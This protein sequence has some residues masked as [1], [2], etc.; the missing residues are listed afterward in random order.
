MSAISSLISGALADA[1][2]YTVFAMSVSEVRDI[3]AVKAEFVKCIGG[4]VFPLVVHGS[5]Q[6]H[7]AL[8]VCV[9]K[10]LMF[11]GTFKQ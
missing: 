8:I 3:S 6:W 4:S 11:K 5:E 2:D 7:H 9:P 1:L 10:D